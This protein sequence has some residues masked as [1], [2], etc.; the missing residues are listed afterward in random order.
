MFDVGWSELMVVAVI[1]VVV[2]GPKDL[3]GVLRG[4]GRVTR[5]MR[6]MADEFR[7]GVDEFIRESE[8]Q[9]LK[10][11]VD[12][13]FNLEKLKAETLGDV[14]DMTKALGAPLVI[15]NAVPVA[16]SVA[17]ETPIV[18]AAGTK[19]KRAAKPR[20][21]KPKATNGAAAP[22]KAAVTK[23]AA[24]RK[25]A[26]PKAGAARTTAKTAAS[27]AATPKAAKAPRKSP[28]KSASAEPPKKDA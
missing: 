25:A 19:P 14:D 12:T 26:T 23:P 4:L 17:S 15:G 3:P 5:K 20:A 6:G 27:K 13:N 1:L 11:S 28:G 2:V 10:K 18:V 24:S 16:E 9:E 22:V 7:R 8:L 21:A